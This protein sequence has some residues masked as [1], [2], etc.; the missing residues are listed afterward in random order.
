LFSPK[1]AE[2][3]RRE[4]IRAE[5]KTP[6]KYG[7]RPGSNIKKRPCRTPAD[8]YVAGSY[9]RAIAR[10]CELAFPAPAGLDAKQIKA[11][12]KANRWHPHQLRHTAAKN[13]EAARAVMAQVG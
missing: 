6:L 10:A 9:R 4:K 2:P 1:E 5:R 12:H 7:D 8:E 3:L 11:W 13:I